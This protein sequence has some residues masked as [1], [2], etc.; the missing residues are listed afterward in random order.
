M[1]L[2]INQF[3]DTCTV[4]ASIAKYARAKRTWKSGH[5]FYEPLVSGGNLLG[6]WVLPE[7]YRKIGFFWEMDSGK[8]FRIE[9][10]A[11]ERDGLTVLRQATEVN[12][13]IAFVFYI[14]V[15]HDPESQIIPLQSRDYTALAGHD[16]VCDNLGNPYPC[17]AKDL[18]YPV[19]RDTWL[20]KNETEMLKQREMVGGAFA[21]CCEDGF[22]AHDNDKGGALNAAHV[23]AL[24][25]E[26]F[27]DGL[28]KPQFHEEGLHK[29]MEAGGKVYATGF[30]YLLE[31]H[32]AGGKN[33]DGGYGG[34]LCADPYG[35][36]VQNMVENLLAQS[37]IDRT[38]CY[39]NFTAPCPELT[40]QQT[41]Q[42][43][44]FDYGDK[45]LKLPCGPLPWP[46]GCPHPNYKPKTNPLTGRW[47]TVSG[48]QAAFIKESIKA[49]ML[50]ASEAKKILS[51]T[52]H[53]KT[54][55]M[56]LRINQFSDQCTVDASIAKYARAKRTWRSGHYFY[57]PLVSGGN[58][59][60]VWVLPEEYRKIGFFWEME[61]GKCF[62]IERRAFPVGPYMILR[63]A[64][65]V[66]GKASFVFYVKVSN[67]PGSKPIPVQSRDYTALAGQD[68][69]CENLG[70]PYPCIGKD[71]DYPK[72]RDTWLDTNKAAMEEQK[73][74][75]ATVFA[76]VCEKGFEVGSGDK[77]GGALNGEQIE[78]Y[79]DNFKNGMHQPSFNDE[80]LHKPM[81]ANGK[82]Y[83]SG[84]HYLL[85]CRDLGGKN[86][87]GGY[88]GPLCRDPY[89]DEVQHLVEKLLKEADND[90]SLCYNNFQD[91]CPELTKEQVQ[92]CKG[93]D[94]GDKTKTLPCGPLPWPAG[95]PEPGYV[96]KTNPLTGLWITVSGGQAAF[97]KES[98][99]A[100]MLGEAEAHKIMADTDHEKT[101][102]M[103]LRINQFG[104][105]CTV[106]ASVA[107][108]ARAKRTWRSG[109][110]FYEPLGSG[111]NLLGVW[112]LPE[113]YRKIGFFW[114]MESGK[115]FRIERRAFP[116][117]PYTFLRQ[118]TEVNGK[119]SF[120]LYVKVSNDPESKPIPVQSRD[121]T[122]LA[123]CDN[124]CTNLGKPD[125]CTAKDLDYPKKRDTWLDQNKKQMLYQRDVVAG[126]FKAGVTQ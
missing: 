60:G 102:G 51:D 54:G 53:E 9:R 39:N 34:P 4:D 115:C 55:G 78:K 12:G 35:E 81:E 32:E 111:G 93:F 105:Q 26:H 71:L 70:N 58:L 28:H 57:E 104:E 1:Y 84:F 96:P 19:K 75:V 65:E 112:V 36:E 121:Y 31:A 72:K 82:T 103:F 41:A 22:E 91:P 56:Y 107:K 64:T 108:Y 7:E 120:V 59:M 29:P 49:G 20:D 118:S 40:K 116:A 18:D 67:D 61:S 8:C 123:G 125:P 17:I 126:T 6:V 3:G 95:C 21:H 15:S 68:N 14:K 119:I 2:R 74:Q 63:Q 52:D 79:G 99:K 100:G 114:E 106:D 62:R 109:H 24:G 98:I 76:N 5:Y 42:C 45:T 30:H 80:G 122:A 27:V 88:G 38:L 48:G 47:I 10:R 44:G 124:V 90:R 101:G 97:I 87:D 43:K 37:E 23:E 86:T 92:K 16:N 46:A 73:E 113:E 50:G 25:K 85:E 117:G 13:K 77:K 33:A 69:V 83:E 89:G 94:Y 11:F 66:N 110:Y